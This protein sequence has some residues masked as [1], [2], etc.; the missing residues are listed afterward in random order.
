MLVIDALFAVLKI[1]CVIKRMIFSLYTLFITL[2]DVFLE[3]SHVYI[4]FHAM[5]VSAYIQ[6]FIERKKKLI[7]ISLS[8]RTHAGVCMSSRPDNIVNKHAHTTCECVCTACT[9]RNNKNICLRCTSEW[10]FINAPRIAWRR[11]RALRPSVASARV[12]DGQ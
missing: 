2:R 4:L 1:T 7:I 11:S 12:R 3:F 10:C 8:R 5:M 6:D 9:C